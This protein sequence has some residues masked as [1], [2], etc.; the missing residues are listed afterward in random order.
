MSRIPIGLEL[1][2]VRRELAAD[3]KGTMQKVAA[4]GYEGVEFAGDPKL[5]AEEYRALLDDSG[6][7]CCGWHTPFHMVQDDRLA[8][9]VA[10]NKA[11]GNTRI[12]IPGLPGQYTGSR[13]GWLRA[14]EFMNALAEKLA[15]EGMQTGYHNH[16][17]EF[18]MLEGIIPWVLFGENTGDDV[19]LQVDTGNCYAGGG[20]PLAMLRRFPGRAGTTHL[21]P[22]SRSKGSQDMR[23]GFRTM[24]GEDD[25]PWD[26]IFSFCE[27]EGG[28]EWYIVEYETDLY[29]SIEGVER[30]LKALGAMGKA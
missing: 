7:V 28:T 6:L 19:I 5:S 10:L 12:I 20:D 17:V 4:M 1:F 11:V 16:T 2:S 25:T 22:F 13:D 18:Q 9:T 26:E 3:P 30:C 27:T 23:E 21:K 29:P 15:S 14:A 24:I 8:D